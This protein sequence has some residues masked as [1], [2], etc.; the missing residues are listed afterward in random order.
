M[1]VT[2]AININN[3]AN[4]IALSYTAMPQ[5][6]WAIGDIQGC[7]QSFLALLETLPN[8]AFVYL[9]GDVLNRGPDNLGLLNWVMQNQHRCQMILGNHELHVLGA[10]L[11]IKP[12]FSDDTAKS[13]EQ[14]ANKQTIIN[15]LLKQPLYVL[16]Q[17][18][19]L[20]HAGLHPLLTLQQQLSYADVFSKQLS[21][22][23]TQAYALLSYY[24]NQV[25]ST[26]AFN[27]DEISQKDAL[28]NQCLAVKALTQIR[29]VH[30]NGLLEAK[31][32]GTQAPEGCMPWWNHPNNQVLMQQTNTP[33]CIFGHWSTQ[34]LLNQKHLIG[35]D[36]ACLWGDDLTAVNL[37][38][39][40]LASKQNPE[41]RLFKY[42]KS[43]DGIKRPWL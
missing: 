38:T 32:K 20:V 35:L 10:L 11:G 3:N 23:S 6:A 13:I 25:K 16:N 41:Q 14:A 39:V 33:V 4:S 34:G 43:L 17:N 28:N 12:W 15:F 26:D 24:F 42:V 7:Y 29:F 19:L 22:N 30:A 36:T 18:Y 5:N 9:V 27:I 21:A 8:N 2:N 37:Q 1:Q 40:T 31:H